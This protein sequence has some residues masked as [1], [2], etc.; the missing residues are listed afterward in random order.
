MARPKNNTRNYTVTRSSPDTLN[1]YSE[2]ETRLASVSV[3][4]VSKTPA[5]DQIMKTR[6]MM[7]KAHRNNYSK[8]QIAAAFKTSKQTVSMYIAA[9]ENAL[10]TAELVKNQTI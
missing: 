3:P 9:V 1:S 4:N 6:V 5:R 8:A 2:L 10:R 7:Y